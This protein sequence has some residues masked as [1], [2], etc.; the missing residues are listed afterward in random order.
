MES[1]LNRQA[2]IAQTHIE[3][4]GWKAI[5]GLLVLLAIAGIR[6]AVR[7]PAVPDEGRDAIHSWLVDDYEGVGTKALVKIAS[8]YQAGLPINLP[9]RPAVP[10]QVEFVSL[11]A[12]GSRD[13][14]IVRVEVSVNGAMPPDDRPVRYLY[15][16][17]KFGGGWMVK[18]ETS[19]LG[20][21]EALVR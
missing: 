12:H 9:E 18:S 7:F 3:L 21:Y 8:D 20:Y 10:P 13:A 6:L 2:P 16:A 14:M 17:R 11:A 1:P 5:A 19:E 15:L 4:T